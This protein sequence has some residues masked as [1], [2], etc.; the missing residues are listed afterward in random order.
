[1]RK[2]RNTFPI[3]VLLLTILGG[4]MNQESA[5]VDAPQFTLEKYGR[6]FDRISIHPNSEEWLFTECSRELNPEGDCHLLRYNINRKQLQRYILPDGYL[7][8]YA[9]FS[10]QGNFIVISRSPKHDGSDEKIQQSFENGEIVMMRSDGTD[11]KVLPIPKGRNLAPVMSKDETKIAYWKISSQRTPGGGRGWGDFDMHEYDLKTKQDT[12]FAGPFHFVSGG[13]SQYVSENEIMINS[14]GPRKY[15]QSMTDYQKKFNS[16]E[17]YILK[18]GAIDMPSP[19]FT[20]VELARQPSTDREGNIYLDG[21]KMP[22]V[23]SALFRMA[24]SGEITIWRQPYLGDVG[25]QH[26]VV[27]PNGLYIAFIYSAD[28][29]RWAEKKRAMGMLDTVSSKWIPVSIPL[30]QASVQLVVK[31]AAE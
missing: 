9:S 13:N 27:S 25:P 12:L 10:P 18:R 26:P 31:L 16:S 30:L 15:A 2:I 14:Y 21:Q 6:D 1:M 8:S 20:E 11:F 22:G 3:V 24:P 23:G 29:T 28:G 5:A 7:Y 17:V 19:T 4:C